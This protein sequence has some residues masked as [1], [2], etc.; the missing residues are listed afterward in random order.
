[1]FS[2]YDQYH[3]RGFFS[4][5]I[6]SNRRLSAASVVFLISA[7]LLPLQNISAPPLLL[8]PPLRC[9]FA[10]SSSCFAALPPSLFHFSSVFPYV[11][12]HS[13]A[14]MH[15][16]H[17]RH[18]VLFLYSSL[19]HQFSLPVPFSTVLSLLS[20]TTDVPVL[21]RV[22]IC[23]LSYVHTNKLPSTVHE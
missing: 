12:H 4:Q 9:S 10:S 7:Y 19:K 15:L 6:V 8:S 11:H 20:L 21:H 3:V 17:H 5:Y 23:F 18:P 14:Q 2:L 1:M 13:R 16:Q 22:F